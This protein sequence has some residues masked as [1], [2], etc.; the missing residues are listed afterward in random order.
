CLFLFEKELAEQAPD[1]QLAVG[2][3]RS[4]HPEPSCGFALRQ[5]LQKANLEHVQ[6]ARGKLRLLEAID[7]Q[8]RVGARFPAGR[9]CVVGWGAVG[10]HLAALPTAEIDGLI[11]RDA[12]QPGA[13]RPALKRS[14]EVGVADET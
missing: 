2:Q 14:P 6:P 12:R 7:Q 4:P 9:G 3:R 5:L 8:A 1:S 13:E 10:I 11:P